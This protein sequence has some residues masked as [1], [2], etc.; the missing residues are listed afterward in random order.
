MKNPHRRFVFIFLWAF[1]IPAFLIALFNWIID[2]FDYYHSPRWKHLNAVKVS[3]EK[4]QRLHKSLEIARLKPTAI[5]LGS[6]RLMAGLNPDDFYELRGEKAYNA[7]FAG[8][9]ME[10]IYHY[11]EHA[12]HHQPQLKVVIIGLDLFAFGQHKR[13]QKDFSLSRL[14]AN[15]FDWKNYLTVLW[16][17][18][19]LKSSYETSQ[20]NYFDQPVPYFLP[21]GFY[22]PLAFSEKGFL[23]KD[24]TSYIKMI[25]ENRD[26]YYGFRL[27]QDKIG[28]F[29]KLVRTCQEKGIEL[30]AFFCPA[31]A[32]YWRSL[33]EHGLGPALEKL[34][35]ELSAIHPIWDFSGFNCVTQ[36][37]LQIDTPLYYECSHFRPQVGRMILEKMFGHTTE[38]ADFGRLLSN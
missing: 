18:T 8:A 10:E 1:G 5:F 12:L 35:Q 27:G 22:N 31:K 26:F 36:E 7:G 2:P 4:Q 19:A 30:H 38:P 34:K 33:N 23:A 37:T 29:K 11:F 6:S 3:L 14:K 13:P 21:N 24:D 16:S 20:A 28:F 9:S 25:F 15:I 32:L 17:Q